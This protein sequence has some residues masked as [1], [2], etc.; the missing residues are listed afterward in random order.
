MKLEPIIGLEIH[1]QLKTKSKMFCSCPNGVEAPPNSAI[2]PVCMGH[3]GTLPVQNKAAIDMGVIAALALH[4]TINPES[5]FDRKNYFYPDLPKGY[6]ISQYDKPVGVDGYVEVSAKGGKSRVGIIRLH[7]EEDAAKLIHEV[8]H[9]ELVEGSPGSRRAPFTLVDFNRAGTP[10]AEIVTKPDLRSPA[11]AKTFLHALRLMLRYCNISEADM[12]KG[13]LRC[14]ANISLRPLDKEDRFFT[15]TEIKNMNSFK[16]V[17]RALEY[18][19]QRQTK[20]WEKHTPPKIQSTR[21]WNDEKGITEEQRVK[22]EAHDYRYFPEPDIPPLRFTKEY[23]ERM[24]AKI[25]ELPAAKH[26]RFIDEFDMD[27]VD[28]AIILEDKHLA[29]WTE[30]AIG[31]LREWLVALEG[32]G[33][34]EEKWNRDHK[35]L[36]KLVTGWI[37]TKLFALMNEAKI[38]GANIPI[39]PENFAEFITFIYQNK[40]NSTTAQ[41]VLTAMFKEKAEP[42]HYIE[43]KKMA[44]VSDEDTI[45]DV[46]H[47]VLEEQIEA[48]E[49][50]KKGKTGALQ[51]LIGQV[52]KKMKGRANPVLVEKILKK[53]IKKE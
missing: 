8:N 42:H 39:T 15:K 17:E 23:V 36:V 7:L 35:R 46:V 21:G 2:C 19:I 25:P 40:I 50:Y 34:E 24:R 49:T 45:S 51:F 10:L 18:E 3:P 37:T 44:Q 43:E 13:Q 4:C 9:P 14:D 6:Q 22:E 11:E 33:T 29:D 27:P 30:H 52:M 28:I 26:K 48:V 1:V 12:E 5:K 20:L 41:E 53:N 16:S 31:E 38:T 47:D 32:E